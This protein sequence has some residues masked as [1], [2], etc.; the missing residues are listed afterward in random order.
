M[1]LYFARS[2]SPLALSV[3]CSIVTWCVV[4]DGAHKMVGAVDF[5]GNSA[6]NVAIVNATI[7]HIPFLK[8]C[9]LEN[10]SRT[11]VCTRRH[12]GTAACRWSVVARESGEGSSI[13]CYNDVTVVTDKWYSIYLFV[14]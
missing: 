9:T 11:I 2:S 14:F 8:V 12:I 1:L 6:R 5:K 13:L 4:R 7:D 10:Q 3:L